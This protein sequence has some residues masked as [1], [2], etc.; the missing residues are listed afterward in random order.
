MAFVGA[1]LPTYCKLAKKESVVKLDKKLIVN[2]LSAKKEELSFSWY[3]FSEVLWPHSN[4]LFLAVLV[5]ANIQAS[6]IQNIILHSLLL[7]P[8]I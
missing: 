8:S 2:E 4:W 1:K 3:K 5:S 6:T 7:H